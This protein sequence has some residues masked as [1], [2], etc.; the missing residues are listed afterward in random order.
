M[1]ILFVSGGSVGHLAPLVAVMRAV[2]EMEPACETLFLC[3]DRREDSEFLAKEG[4]SFETLPLPRLSWRL[5][6]RFLKNF[7]KSRRVL[8]TFQ[9]DIVFSKGGAVSVPCCLAAKFQRIP[10][11][12]HESDAVM[13]RAN[14]IVARWAEIVCLGMGMEASRKRFLS[15]YSK[16]EAR[17]PKLLLTGNPIRQELLKGNREEGLKLTHLSGSRPILLVLGGS[18]GA[19]ALNAVVRDRI[20]AILAHCDVIHLTGFGKKGA[21]PRS[22]YFSRE[23][24][25]DELP[26]LYAVASLAL[27]RAGANSISEL[28]AN[29]IP[30]ILVPIE[31]LAHNHQVRNAEVAASFGATVLP[32]E[33]LSADLL[34][35]IASWTG[36]ADILRVRSEKVRKLQ[37]QEAARRI[38]EILVRRIARGTKND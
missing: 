30:M 27:S 26:H 37:P 28:A 17:S 25:Y 15:Y 16:P 1:R 13:G 31:G 36:D 34:S 12:L 9:P 14:R 5:P 6:T 10:I 35:L 24:A 3:S 20:D 19:E 33:N 2:K 4:V 21:P 23:F 22:G 11:V 32:Q 18:Q 38:A 7:F 8:G 29:G